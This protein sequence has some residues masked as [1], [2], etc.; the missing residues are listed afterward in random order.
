MILKPMQ[1][2]YDFVVHVKNKLYDHNFIKKVN[3]GIPIISIGNLSVGG[4]GKTPCV[5]LVASELMEK[6]LCSGKKRQAERV[7]IFGTYLFWL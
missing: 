1:F 4:T 3:L 2:M 5:Y 7:W 6:K